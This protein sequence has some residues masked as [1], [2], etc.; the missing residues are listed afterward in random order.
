MRPPTARDP[1]LVAGADQGAAAAAGPARLQRSARSTA[2]W[3]PA[4]APAS[5]RRRSSSGC[6]A[7]SYPTPELL[8]RLRAAAVRRAGRRFQR[9]RSSPAASARRRRSVRARDSRERAR[10]PAASAASTQPASATPDR[11]RH[12]QVAQIAVGIEL[13]RGA[14]VM[15]GLSMSTALAI[16]V[17]ATSA[18]AALRASTVTEVGDAER[19]RAAPRTRRGDAADARGRIEAHRRR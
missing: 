3:A 16:S 8:E 14:A 9:A 12:R 11:Y 1:R 10:A 6:P 4:H 5:R 15:A 7:D 13:A 2:R 19:E 17:A 18:V